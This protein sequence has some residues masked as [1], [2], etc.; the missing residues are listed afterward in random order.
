MP[1]GRSSSTTHQQGAQAEDA[2][3]SFLQ[4]QG[5]QL[6]AQNFNTRFGEID[7]IVQRADQLVFVEVRQRKANSLVSALESITLAKQRK[8]IRAA[9]GFLQQHQQ[10]YNN[11]CRFDVIALTSKPVPSSKKQPVL[12]K[13]AGHSAPVP[14]ELEWIQAAF[15]SA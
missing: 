3:A 4:Q 9:Q 2:A 14:F 11:D 8:I 10:Y 5:Y 6:V 15:D 12:A 1:V 13:A 7:L